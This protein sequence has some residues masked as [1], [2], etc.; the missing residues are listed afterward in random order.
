M[1]GSIRRRGNA[2]QLR[3]YVGREEVIRDLLDFAASD[4][5][6]ACLVTGPSGAG[7]S[8]ALARFVAE[9]RRLH[10][11]AVV[12]PHFV[13]AGPRSTSLRETLAASSFS[14]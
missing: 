9:Y 10:P 5:P 4:A 7:K 1:K 2:W 12:L 8:A 13:G 14:F 6:V 11:A 3:V